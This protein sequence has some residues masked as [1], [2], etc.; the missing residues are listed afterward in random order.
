MQPLSSVALIVLWCLIIIQL[1]CNSKIAIN[2]HQSSIPFVIAD[3]NAVPLLINTPLTR[4]L[5]KNT[6]FITAAIKAL[7]SL[8][9]SR[10]MAIRP[11]QNQLLTGTLRC[12]RG[13][14]QRPIFS[15]YLQPE[16]L[17]CHT[18]STRGRPNSIIRTYLPPYGQPF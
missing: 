1:I 15:N 17:P 4:P 13:C 9:I 11:I 12:G 14:H 8:L 7:V 16:F 10:H 6:S 5:S 18:H 2:I 3:L